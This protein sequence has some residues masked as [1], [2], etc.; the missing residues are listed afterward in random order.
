M[1]HIRSIDTVTRPVTYAGGSVPRIVAD[2]VRAK[3]DAMI[4]I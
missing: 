1:S 4:R 2:E 3:L